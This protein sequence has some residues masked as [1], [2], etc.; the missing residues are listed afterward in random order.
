MIFCDR[1]ELAVIS[2]SGISTELSGITNYKITG[3]IILYSG[4]LDRTHINACSA[5]Q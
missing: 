2:K 1:T 3:H 5:A 4:C